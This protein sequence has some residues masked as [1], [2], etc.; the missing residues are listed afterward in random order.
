[1]YEDAKA[2]HLLATHCAC[3][4]RPL[5]DARSVETGMGPICRKRYGFDDSIPE[6]AR[7]EANKLIYTIARHQKGEHV[8]GA[9]ARLKDLGFTKLVDRI[10]KR[11]RKRPSVEINC[12]D[13]RLI[14]KARIPAESWHNWLNALRQVPGRKYEGE[15]GNSFP[16]ERKREVYQLLC[17]YLPGKTGVGPKGEF[18]IRA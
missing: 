6:E 9:L 13:G 17:E 4:S 15:G 7:K 14:L 12:N 10:N 18:T 2:T 16:I 8:E 1:M 3:C 11:L 5:L